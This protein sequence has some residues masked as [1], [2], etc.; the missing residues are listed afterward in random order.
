[1]KEKRKPGI[2]DFKAAIEVE[3]MLREGPGI[4]AG[5]QYDEEKLRKEL[6]KFP[7]D[8]TGEEAYNRLIYLLAEDYEQLVDESKNLD[9]SYTLDRKLPKW[10]KGERERVAN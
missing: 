10:G 1:M 9:I 3:E 7:E 5:D 4:F 8:L 2:E 6:D